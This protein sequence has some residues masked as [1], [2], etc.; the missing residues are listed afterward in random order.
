MTGV[1]LARVS[2]DGTRLSLASSAGSRV[3][4]GDVTFQHGVWA[5]LSNMPPA[6]TC[7]LSTV[8]SECRSDGKCD[9]IYSEYSGVQ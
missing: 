3:E 8:Q 1:I 2:L 5:L 6:S 7:R 4:R 9:E